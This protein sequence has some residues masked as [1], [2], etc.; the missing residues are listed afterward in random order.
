MHAVDITRGHR[1]KKRST[2]VNFPSPQRS[3][4]CSQAYPILRPHPKEPAAT[5]VAVISPVGL[6]ILKVKR[7]QVSPNQRS[8]IFS[9]GFRYTRYSKC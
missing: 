6:F 3:F 4:S 5:G 1:A 7:Y 9:L 2:P 8:Q